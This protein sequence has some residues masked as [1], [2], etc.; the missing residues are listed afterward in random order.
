MLFLVRLVLGR[1][2]LT[3]SLWNGD[4]FLLCDFIPTVSD[5]WE[6]HPN[7]TTGRSP[8]IA[9]FAHEIEVHMLNLSFHQ[10]SLEFVLMEIGLKVFI[11]FYFDSSF[12]H[13]SNAALCFPFARGPL[14]L[15]GGSATRVWHSHIYFATNTYIYGQCFKSTS[16]HSTVEFLDDVQC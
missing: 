15:L 11:D 12:I 6:V 4:S 14:K 2:F 5:P 7:S 1:Y 8:K 16:I 13:P 3:V 9:R 10:R